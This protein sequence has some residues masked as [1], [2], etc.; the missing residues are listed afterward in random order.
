[1]NLTALIIEDEPHLAELF[2]RALGEVGYQTEVVAD[3]LAAAQRIKEETVPDLVI[4]DLHL[5]TVSGDELLNQI[6]S[7]ERYN[8]TKVILATADGLLGDRLRTQAN[9]VMIK[10]IDIFQL[11][12]LANRLKPSE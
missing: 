8:D 4:L 2:S 12:R 11:Q 3:G 6:K 1:M 7:N 10:P 9:L 5:P